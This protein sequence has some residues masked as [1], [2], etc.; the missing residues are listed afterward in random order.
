MVTSVSLNQMWHQV[1]RNFR[2]MTICMVTGL[3]LSQKTKYVDTFLVLLYI[4]NIR[5]TQSPTTTV[6]F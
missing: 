2:E 1:Y 5:K 6:K 4:A 3:E